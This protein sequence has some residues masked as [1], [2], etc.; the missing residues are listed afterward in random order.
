MKSAALILLLAACR[1]EREEPASAEAIRRATAAE[2]QAQPQAQSQPAS[3]PITVRAAD[4]SELLTVA[5]ADAIVQI[6]FTEAGTQHTLRGEERG[7][8]KRKYQVD[9]GPVLFEIKPDGDSDGFKLRKA[10]GTLR[11][12]VKI[13]PEKIKISDNEQNANPFELKVREGDRVKVVGPGEKELGNVRFDRAAS[14]T[15]VETAGGKTAFMAEG[16]KP[17]GAYGVLLLDSIPVHERYVLM[18]ELL[19]RGR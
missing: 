8:G 18:A 15:E 19:S 17:S 7:S 5:E 4:G 13:T 9:G 2:S 11:W 3:K 14:K 1:G 12:K 10:D 6:S 16:S